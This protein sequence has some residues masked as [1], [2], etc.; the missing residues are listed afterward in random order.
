MLRLI[1]A[2]IVAV[3]NAIAAAYIAVL[4][5]TQT[6]NRRNQVQRLRPIAIKP[7]AIERTGTTETWSGKIIYL[8]EGFYAMVINR[9]E[10]NVGRNHFP[11]WLIRPK[12]RYNKTRPYK[13][14]KKI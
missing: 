9:P 7:K 1:V 2:W 14:N 10:N 8:G 3:A 6:Q 12:M 11:V 5:Y 13:H 4:I